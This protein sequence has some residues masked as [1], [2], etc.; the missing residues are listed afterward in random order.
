MQGKNIILTE[1]GSHSIFSERFQS[2]YHSSHGAIQE[3]EHVFIKHGLDYYY[4][5]TNHDQISILEY[6]FG[7]GLNALLSL[8]YAIDNNI[9]INYFGIEAYPLKSTEYT[10]LNY[11]DEIKLPELHKHFQMMHDSEDN[12]NLNIHPK[13]IF[14]KKKQD[15]EEF[16][17]KTKYDIVYFDAFSPDIQSHLWERP[18]LDKVIDN[19]KPNGILITYGAKGTFKRALKSLGLKIENPPGPPG[20]REI[21]RAIKQ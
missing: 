7:T 10:Q 6:G 12:S 19:L 18:F 14:S 17:S 8:K 3:S 21:T 16:E 5:K 2:T 13:F 11:I 9:N 1:D 20:K 15:F 4:N